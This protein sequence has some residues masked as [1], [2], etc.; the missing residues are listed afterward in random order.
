MTYEE[1]QVG[2]VFSLWGEKARFT[3]AK[4]VD[5]YAEEVVDERGYIEHPVFLFDNWETRNDY[6]VFREKPS[7]ASHS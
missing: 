7:G 6:W 4:G 3:K 2:D 1:L 5:E